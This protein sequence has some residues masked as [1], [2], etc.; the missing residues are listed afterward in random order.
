MCICSYRN[1]YLPL[2]KSSRYSTG[3]GNNG[4]D[5]LV[6]ARHLRHFGYTPKVIYPKEGRGQLF[7]NL[8]KQ[9]HDLQIPIFASAMDCL[10]NEGE[11]T[12][13]YGGDVDFGNACL[14]VDSIFGFSYSGPPRS[15]FKELIEALA[16]TSTPTLSVDIPSGWAVDKGD[17]DA[18]A[19]T[20]D[21]VVS[22]TAPKLCMDGF[23][24]KHYL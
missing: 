2:F 21:A 3:P 11:G 16:R 10:A 17:I 4:G 6:A 7:E 5:G 24:G 8:V 13:I 20:P 18:T 14:I 9:C 12:V 1:I 23:K 22:L 15:P 19:F